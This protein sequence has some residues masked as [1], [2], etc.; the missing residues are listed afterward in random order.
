MTGISA[1]NVHVPFLESQTCTHFPLASGGQGTG[2]PPPPSGGCESGIRKALLSS[3]Q[4]K[5]APHPAAA[6]PAAAPAEAAEAA[7]WENNWVVPGPEGPCTTPSSF[8]GCPTF[9]PRDL[10][11]RRVLCGTQFGPRPTSTSATDLER[12]G[13]RSREM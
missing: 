11:M 10:A 13:A 4:P 8:L 3:A 9:S 1:N 5:P 12:P 7:L 2:L 6:A